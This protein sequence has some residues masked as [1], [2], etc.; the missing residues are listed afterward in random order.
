MKPQGLQNEAR[1]GS[2]FTLPHPGP[3]CESRPGDGKATT[4]LQHGSWVK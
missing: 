3:L 4:R 1:Q 2:A